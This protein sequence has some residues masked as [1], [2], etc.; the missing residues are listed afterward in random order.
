M[1]Y[2]EPGVRLEKSHAAY[3][4]ARLRLARYRLENDQSRA[5]GAQH[6]TQV[7]AEALQ[8]E[9]VGVWLLRD[10]GAR[11][12]CVSQYVRSSGKHGG[13]QELFAKR[14]PTY[15]RALQERRAVVADDAQAHEYTCE[16]KDS[17]LMPNGITSML[18]AP[19]IHRGRVVGVVCHEH[20]GPRRVWTQKDIDFASS[21]ADM[22]ALIFE[23]AD[24]LELEAAL[25]QRTELRLEQQKMEALGRVARAVAHDFNNVLATISLTVEVMAQKA[26]PAL[27]NYASEALTMIG[28]GRRL[29]QQLLSFG[30][31]QDGS[32]VG[33][34]DLREI[35]ARIAPMVRTAIG[36][37]IGLDVQ[38]Q[39]EDARVVI[40][41]SQLEQVLLN[42]CLNARDAI[43]GPGEIR[44]VLR[45][46]ITED[47]VAPDQVVL[48]VK[49][50][51]TGMTE[52]VSTHVFEP[53]FTTKEKGTGLGLATV[54]GIVRRA[55]GLVQVLSA[56]GEGTTMFVALPR[57][58]VS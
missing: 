51:G 37:S 11:L 26:D 42:L 32:S 58:L 15:V 34:I 16:L 8:V 48:E 9:R 4:T 45:D 27:R 7:S 5:Q 50:N 22:L 30:T 31:K 18:D 56:P 38:V 36:E 44:V 29:T 35:L 14:Y 12:S 47:D 25:Q 57:A 43:R 20:V 33:L 24:R 6:A 23:Q 54:Y 3:E 40:D 2:L 28:V 10:H 52:A 41:P 13:G 49:D 17:Y 21:V 39:T 53:F 1:L 19:I 46:P 55:G